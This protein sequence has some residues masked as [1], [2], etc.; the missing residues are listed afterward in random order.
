MLASELD[1]AAVLDEVVQQ[2]PV[3]LNADACAV[4]TLEEDELVVGAA[5]GK[6]AEDAVG[7]RVSVTDRLSGDVFQSPTS[8]ERF[9][10]SNTSVAPA[11]SSDAMSG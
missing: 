10:A 2:A 11:G 4:R 9:L 6:G 8:D 5:W 1:P 7:T 3:L